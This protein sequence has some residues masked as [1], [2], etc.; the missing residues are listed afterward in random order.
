MS[1]EIY[2]HFHGGPLAG[3]DRIIR[4]CIAIVPGIDIP[5]LYLDE[6]LP[7]SY[8]QDLNSPGGRCYDWIE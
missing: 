2:A 8:A 7:G 3:T 1:A 6:P 4:N 5:D